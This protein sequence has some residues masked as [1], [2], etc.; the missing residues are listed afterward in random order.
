VACFTPQQQRFVM[1]APPP[2][3]PGALRTNRAESPCAQVLAV[4]DNAPLA[5]VMRRAMSAEGVGLT[6]A[7]SGEQALELVRRLRF[8]LIILNIN[9]PGIDGLEV[10]RRLKQDPVLRAVPVIFASGETNRRFMVEA[11]RLGA[12]DYLTKPFGLHDFTTRVLAQLRP[13]AASGL[14]GELHWRPRPSIMG[15]F[16]AGQPN[17]APLALAR[18]LYVEDQPAVAALVQLELEQA[19]LSV[20]TVPSGE[21]GL[22]LAH[23][24]KFDLILLDH[25]LPGI[26]GLEVCRRLKDDA[27]LHDVP[28]I[29]LTAHPSPADEHEAVRLGAV[30]YLRKGVQGPRLAARILAEVELA[31]DRTSRRSKHPARDPHPGAQTPPGEN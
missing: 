8:D 17:P 22:S 20:T 21:H 13:L 15:T 5:L 19:R 4:E 14:G 25:L 12:V 11:F 1:I 6:I 31:H 23:A 3:A 30:D 29:F 28:V 27:S 26:S 7:S 10:C 2:D 16:A 18:I 9:L 24:Q